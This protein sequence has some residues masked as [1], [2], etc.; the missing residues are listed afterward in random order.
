MT[1]AA[2]SPAFPTATPHDR[3][4]ICIKITPVAGLVSW[5]GLGLGGDRS[6]IIFD[7]MKFLGNETALYFLAS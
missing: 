4:H 1:A 5:F 2:Q 3:I 6:Q 7:L